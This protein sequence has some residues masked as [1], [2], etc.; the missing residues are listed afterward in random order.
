[1]SA[2]TQD[3]AAAIRSR[4]GLT[5]IAAFCSLVSAAAFAVLPVLS[6]AS[7][8]FNPAHPWLFPIGAVAFASNLRRSLHPAVRALAAVAQAFCVFE[9]LGFSVAVSLM[10]WARGWRA[11]DWWLPVTTWILLCVCLRALF[12]SARTAWPR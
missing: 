8:T 10:P 4:F 9:L 12:W 2:D 5:P 7:P 1:M 3:S 11:D 6:I